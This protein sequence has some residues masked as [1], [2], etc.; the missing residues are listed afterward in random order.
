M[1]EERTKPSG[2]RSSHE[3]LGAEAPVSH[4]TRSFNAL[5]LLL[6][7]ANIVAIV[8]FLHFCKGILIPLVIAFFVWHLVNALANH[9]ARSFPSLRSKALHISILL[10]ITLI[11]GIMQLGRFSAYQLLSEIPTLSKRWNEVLGSTVESVP[12]LN[13]ESL[14]LI[15]NGS[16]DL[17]AP[18]QQ[19]ARG[20]LTL[21]GSV[22]ITLLYV[23][24]LFLEQSSF[25][26]KLPRIWSNQ[27]SN[28]RAT[29]V[30][31]S[32]SEKIQTYV[33][34]KSLISASTGLV[35][36]IILLMLG[37]KFAE[38]WALLTFILNYIP[39]IGSFFAVAG[40]TLF[41]FIQFEHSSSSVLLLILLTT[42]Q[43]FFGNILEPRLMGR[44]LNLSP[45]VILVSLVTWNALWGIAG[46]FLAV[47]LMVVVTII[48]AEFPSTAWVA[49]LLSNKGELHNASIACRNQNITGSE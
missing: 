30:Y 27:E 37:L 29:L 14:D 19:I 4:N 40:A 39:H 35:S 18:L 20:L 12:F 7:Q 9:L 46:A 38:I 44:S 10:G 15:A 2:E 34:V 6:V 8:L 33:W 48:L 22:F 32:L 47:P 16:I 11:L 24:F 25:S 42:T 49:V 1:T 36:Y 17:S 23:V 41:S 3:T 28:G 21:S 31:E 13:K 5:S 43:I 26:T 45:L